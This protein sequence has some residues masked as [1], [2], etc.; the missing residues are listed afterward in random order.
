[1]NP[2]LPLLLAEAKKNLRLT[3]A[4]QAAEARRRQLEAPRDSKAWFAKFYR[5]LTVGMPDVRPVQ[6]PIEED[7]ARWFFRAVC[8][9]LIRIHKRH[10]SVPASGRHRYAFLIHDPK[11]RDT[12]LD[13]EQITRIAQYAVLVIGRRFPPQ[14]IRW[15]I[16]RKP[17]H[18]GMVALGPW[19]GPWLYAETTTSRAGANELVRALTRRMKTRLRTE[20]PS[21]LWISYPECVGFPSPH[22]F[23]FPYPGGRLR[24]TR[25]PDTSLT[26]PFPNL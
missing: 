21:C 10:F 17:S 5:H 13:R 4:Q 9:N 25:A 11:R 16:K 2:V 24:L 23:R 6:P 26:F 8:Q 20:H 22:I 18:A 19:G 12:S 7:E 15:P 3:T 14:A 1:M